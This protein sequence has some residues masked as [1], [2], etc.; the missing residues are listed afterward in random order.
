MLTSP[1]KDSIIIE[2]P[3]FS[4]I[5]VLFDEVKA[6]TDSVIGLGSAYANVGFDNLFDRSNNGIIIETYLPDGTKV[7]GY[8][9]KQELPGYNLF[10]T[11]HIHLIYFDDGSIAK[12][13]DNG[14]I[15]FISAVDRV[16][17][18]R[19]GGNNKFGEDID[20]WL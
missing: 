5:K 20:F 7:V 2:H 13:L 6:R 3:D 18:N 1:K 16:A 15:V 14:E 4:T 12:V 11:N 10:Q 8:K 17:L 9:E 19:N